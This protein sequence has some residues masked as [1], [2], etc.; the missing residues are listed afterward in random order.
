M[1]SAALELAKQFRVFPLWPVLPAKHRDGF[2]C[3]CGKGNCQ[4]QGK[5]PLGNLVT[6]GVKDATPDANLI[7]HWWR[8]RPDANIGIA[9]GN[10]LTVLDIDPRHGGDKSIVDLQ[11]KHGRLRRRWP[12]RRVAAAG[13]HSSP[14]IC[15]TA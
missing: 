14:V 10:G 8:C 2:V 3:G 11:K 1:K 6:H 13:M 12:Q 15:R 7:D 9:T 4:N 5:H